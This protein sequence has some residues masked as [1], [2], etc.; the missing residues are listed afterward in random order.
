[1]ITRAQRISA[2]GPIDQ[3]EHSIDENADCQLAF[4]ASTGRT[5]TMFLAATLDDIDGVSACHE[6]QRPHDP[7][8]RPVLP[9]INLQNGPAWH[10]SKLA[11]ETVSTRRSSSLLKAA[12][13]HANLLVDVAFYNAPLLKALAAI[14]RS[15]HLLVM[16]RRCE[17]F[18]RSATIIRGED[19]QPAGW[20]DPAKPLTDRERFIQMG[21][22]R[23]APTSAE[24]DAWHSWTAIQRNIWLWHT[25]NSELAALLERSTVITSLFHEQLESDPEAFWATCLQGLGL[26][27]PGLVTSCVD[28]SRNRINARRSYQVGPAQSWTA[29]E[30][31]LY[32]RLALPLEA[33]IYD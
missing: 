14:H 29:D 13:G 1:M 3:P 27:D 4:V 10:D 23:P 11:H 24:A 22:L 25:V 19:L 5:A 2:E 18:V 33:R 7:L 21:R 15:A 12:A 32:E 30:R 17:A 16:F 8:T 9:L 26:N 20:P 6:G 28:R 31:Q